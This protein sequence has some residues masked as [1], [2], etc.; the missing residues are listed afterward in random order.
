[1]IIPDLKQIND[2]LEAS[3]EKMESQKEQIELFAITIVK[4]T[5]MIKHTAFWA[6][7]LGLILGSII[8][9]VTI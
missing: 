4:Q 7:I 3:L 1:M 8:T 2:A 9:M 5:H 6:F